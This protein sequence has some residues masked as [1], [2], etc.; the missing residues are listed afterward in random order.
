[1]AYTYTIVPF[2]DVTDAMVDQCIETSIDDLRHTTSGTDRVI[3]KWDGATPS[4]LSSYTTHTYSD[5]LT[6][7]NE[8]G[9]DWYTEVNI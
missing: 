3:L 8:E 7:L 1:M 9:G 5:I 2:T 6:I 4:L